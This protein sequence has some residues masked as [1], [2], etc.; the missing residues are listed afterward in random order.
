MPKTLK[1]L[2]IV[3]QLAI[4]IDEANERI[5]LL[6]KFVQEMMKEGIDYGVIPGYNKPSLLKPGAEKLCDVFGFS[7]H[8]EVINRVEDWDKKV[9][10]YEIKAILISKATGTVEAEGIGSC[11][12]RERR[13]KN[14]DPYSVINTIMKMAKKRALVD[15]VLSATRSSGIFTQD[16][17]DFIFDVKESEGTNNAANAKQ[18]VSGESYAVNKKQ[19]A[20]IFALVARK[21][22]PIDTVKTLLQDLYGV[23]ESKDLTSIQAE[24]FKS[25]IVKM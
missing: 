11:N 15:A 3:P 17:E 2:N 1:E 7:K 5:A 22:I 12:N 10:H 21:A 4:S 23:I 20:E 6:Q 14:L 18:A 25:H 24:D 8:I 19:L 13:Y 9:F 16:I